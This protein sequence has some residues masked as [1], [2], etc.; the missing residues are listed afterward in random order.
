MSQVI[1]AS[2]TTSE[3][4]L[5]RP[6]WGQF[7]CPQV[8]YPS[9]CSTKSL[10]EPA[11]APGDFHSS[12]RG[13]SF[14]E[15]PRKTGSPQYR[16]DLPPWSRTPDSSLGAPPSLPSPEGS[17]KSG[18]PLRR[19]PLNRSRPAR[20]SPARHWPPTLFQ[21]RNPGAGS[22]TRDR[23]RLGANLRLPLGTQ[24]ILLLSQ[25]RAT[26]KFTRKLGLF[27]VD[28]GCKTLSIIATSL[29]VH[30]AT[31][32]P[33]LVHKPLKSP[34]KHLPAVFLGASLQI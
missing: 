30:T 11:L 5:F 32:Y 13:P 29:L 22:A 14:F 34:Q 25:A 20:N 16:S 31:I 10:K 7:P 28:F 2:C 19:S 8:K 27:L 9:P 17:G 23:R 6:E 12:P 18:A 26:R 24:K 33:H 4:T 1:F 3:G 15:G 21:D